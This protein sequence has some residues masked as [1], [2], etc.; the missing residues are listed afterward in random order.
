[1]CY[2]NRILPV[3]LLTLSNIF[4]GDSMQP[5][6]L[7]DFLWHIEAERQ[8]DFWL[9][10]Q[11]GPG[12]SPALVGRAFP[13]K[14]GKWVSEPI[15]VE[16]DKAYIF[17]A[18]VCSQLNSA[19]GRLELVFL[20]SEGKEISVFSSRTIFWHHNWARYKAVGIAPKGA[21]KAILRFSVWGPEGNSSGN[22]MIAQIHYGK[23][24]DI[25]A[26]FNAKGNVIIY[27]AKGQAMLYFRGVPA[28]FPLKIRWKILDFNLNQVA[29]KE[30]NTSSREL[31][32]SIPPLEPGY[33]ILQIEA[34]GE[35]IIPNDEEVSFGVIN[36]LPKDFNRKESPICLDAGMSW[37]YAPDEKRLDLACYL[38]EIAGIGL[39]RDRLWWGE[40]EKEEGK[41]NWGRY[42]Q[43]AKAQAR[44]NIT[45]YQIFHDCPVWASID[46]TGGRKAGNQPPKD[47]I[48][49]YRMVNRL[50]R[51]LG[52][53]VRYFEVWNEPNI[54]FFNGRPED[55]AAILKAAYLGAKDAD[56]NF[57]IL[58]GSAAG[59][60]GEFYKRVYE[61]DVGGYFDIY[62]QH[63]YG[64]P[65]DLF[66]F[67]PSSVISQLSKFGLED[68]PIWMTEMGMRAYPDENGDFK[69]IERQQASYLVR[70]YTCSFA[71]GISKFFYFYLCEYLEGSVSLW[72]IVR[73]DLT[74]K[75][76][77]IALANL[78]RQLGEAKCI[79]WKKID[80][81][82]L[83]AFRRN[84]DENV[85]VAWGKEGKN[86]TIPAKG[87]IVDIVGKVIRKEENKPVPLAIPL[88]NMPIYIRGLTNREISELQLKPPLPKNDWRPTPDKELN[89]KRTWLQLEVNPGQ[90]RS[91]DESEKWGAFIEPGKPFVVRAWVRN[92]S[93]K[94][95][96]ATLTCQ[97]DDVFSL[98]GEK[99]VKI[100]VKG[101]ESG[102]HDFV[103]IGQNIVQGQEMGVSVLMETS[104]H[105]EKGR[106]YLQSRTSDVKA[107]EE[108]L[109]MDGDCDINQ[110]IPNNS[111]T[112]EVEIRKDEQVKLGEKASIKIGAKIVGRGD[113]WVFPH[114]VLPEDLDLSK[115][116]GLEICSYVPEGKERNAGLLVQLIEEGGGTWMIGGM[117]SLREDGWKRDV[118]IFSSA[119]PTQWGPDPDG[120]LELEKVRKIMIGWGGYSGEIGENIE[121][122]LGKV[123]AIN[124]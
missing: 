46:L 29:E 2:L 111:P 50:V 99:E 31:S 100:R 60:P 8:D 43:S 102:Y 24:V 35:G 109:I 38:C 10:P 87:P 122:W 74:P 71:N 90:P 15:S 20:D 19:Q 84:K 123:S 57:G 120:K 26:E 1:M 12:N 47:P 5:V 116:K 42:E 97:P 55:Y 92:Y 34:S 51:D 101:W 4:W 40:V 77:Y 75:P 118:V 114:I 17:S 59:T 80:D 53:Y 54:G 106:V 95:A 68:K 73:S 49:V 3:F 94:P 79:G 124:W 39:L 110:I 11:G 88:S 72:G 30:T 44:H 32:I 69:E 63:W 78:I 82:Y 6:K 61:N 7:G 83:I 91:G 33:Y 98:Q 104:N 14:S 21:K 18:F 37:S 41:Y 76:T 64:S 23:S 66:N 121:F 16:E 9:D 96:F 115:F 103:L 36:P 45:V 93:D 119:R 108:S 52:K 107:K 22:A 62:N 58:I 56:P 27:P 70:A 28:N 85:I 65:E 113:A 112:T 25:K 81:T 13:G 67:I 89:T 86:I 48:Y 117:R 105:L